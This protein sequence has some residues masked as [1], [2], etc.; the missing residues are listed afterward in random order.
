MYLSD[1][2]LT[3]SLGFPGTRSLALA[4][5]HYAS[6]QTLI[7]FRR[8]SPHL[9]HLTTITPRHH[10]HHYPMHV[11]FTVSTTTSLRCHHRFHVSP[12]RTKFYVHWRE[13]SGFSPAASAKFSGR[14]LCVSCGGVLVTAPS[15]THQS[16]LACQGLSCR[17]L[18]RHASLHAALTPPQSTTLNDR[19]PHPQRSSG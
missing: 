16:G 18:P 1:A 14:N 17:S 4:A 11:P 15:V 8:P 3:C 10:H 6:S 5:R 13:H 2:S 7:A 9:C 19:C 12:P